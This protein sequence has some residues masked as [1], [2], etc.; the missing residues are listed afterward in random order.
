MKSKLETQNLFTF[1][2]EIISGN[3]IFNAVSAAH[4]T[5]YIGK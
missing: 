1:P 4:S 5:K 3:F 2:K